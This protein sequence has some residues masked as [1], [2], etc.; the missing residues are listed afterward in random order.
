VIGIKV[1]VYKGEIV[2]KGRGA[3]E[4]AVGGPPA[5]QP[6]TP[7]SRG[8]ATWSRAGRLLRRALAPLGLPE[9]PAPA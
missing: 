5:A 7:A 9:A 2:P 4:F 8:G 1:W 6:E 3:G